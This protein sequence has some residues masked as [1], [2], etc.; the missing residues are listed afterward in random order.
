MSSPGGI[1]SSII[2]AASDLFGG[3]LGASGDKAAEKAYEQAATFAQENAA[4]SARSGI[5]Q[6]TQANRQIYQAVSGQAAAE[7]AGGTT[8]GGSNQYLTRASLQQGG[9]QRAIIANNAQLQ[10]QGFQAEAAADVGQAKQAAAQA[11]A[12]AGGGILGAIGGILSIF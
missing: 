11:Q 7:A 3:L 8:G 1:A 12:S 5:L 9:L 10:V 2:G 4:V 6:E